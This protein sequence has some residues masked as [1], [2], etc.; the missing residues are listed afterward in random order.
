VAA[1]DLPDR[2]DERHDDQAEG[3]RDEAQVGAR[4]GRLRAALEQQ[5]R[6]HGAGADED[7]QC[8]ADELG[9]QTLR[10]VVLRH[11]P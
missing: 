6:R 11:Q 9:E 2:V 5:D 8:R 3:H 10:D 1:R 4:E 7:E